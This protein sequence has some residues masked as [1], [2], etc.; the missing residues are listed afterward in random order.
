MTKPRNKRTRAR[1]K[2]S[3][4]EILTETESTFVVRSPVTALTPAGVAEVERLAADH[5]GTGAVAAAL[6]LPRRTFRDVM[7]RQEDV[8]L[9]YERGQARAEQELKRILLAQARKGAVVA[10]IYLTKT[11]H[12]WNENNAP[13]NTSSRITLVLPEALEGEAYEFALAARRLPMQRPAEPRAVTHESNL[14]PTPNSGG[15]SAPTAES[16][17]APPQ[18]SR[19]QK[20]VLR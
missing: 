15:T 20:E 5:H 11:Q 2:D 14:N 16:E 3:L 8:A 19:K 13:D 4:T 12:G 7:D 10:A 6:G 1:T 9:A 17:E 18:I